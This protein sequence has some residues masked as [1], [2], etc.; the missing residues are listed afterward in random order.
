M[1]FLAAQKKIHDE[2]WEVCA[3]MSLFWGFEKRS[4]LIESQGI[5][6]PQGGQASEGQNPGL[7]GVP[8]IGDSAFTDDSSSHFTPWEQQM[9]DRKGSK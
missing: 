9:M 5:R 4:L 6:E 8:S 1:Q 2:R 7:E 3:C